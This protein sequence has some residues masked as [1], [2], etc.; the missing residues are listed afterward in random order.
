MVK[1]EE[2]FVRGKIWVVKWG[3][4]LRGAKVRGWEM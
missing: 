3:G 4:N 2:G 1:C